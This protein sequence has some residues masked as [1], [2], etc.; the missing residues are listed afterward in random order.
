MPPSLRLVV[1][2][3]PAL[4]ARLQADTQPALL[5]R[6]AVLRLGGAGSGSE[7]VWGA[8]E[9]G[10]QHG[11]ANVRGAALA[12]LDTP[13][14]QSRPRSLLLSYLSRGEVEGG[15][16]LR[17]ITVTAATAVWARCCGQGKVKNKNK[18]KVETQ[19]ISES[20]RQSGSQSESQLEN[21]V[22]LEKCLAALL[23]QLLP[24]GNYHRR[25]LALDLL[26]ALLEQFPAC[27]S[28]GCKLAA[29]LVTDRHMQL[30][31][32]LLD[33]HM[34]DVKEK[35]AG[36]LKQFRPCQARLEQLQARLASLLCSPREGDS[37]TAA[38]LA[39]LLARWTSHSKEADQNQET[40]TE[41]YIIQNHKKN[42]DQ[43]PGSCQDKGRSADVNAEQVEYGVTYKDQD[44]EVD[45]KPI[46]GQGELVP[47][48]MMQARAS[49]A[50]WRGDPLSGAATS[51]LYPV[52]LTIRRLLLDRD[53]PQFGCLDQA[54]LD[55]LLSMLEQ[56]A[57]LMLTLLG[58]AEA[59]AGG[60]PDFQQ[61]AMAVRRA[62][63]AGEEG[64][65]VRLVVTAAW[66]SLK[67]VC[68]LA[69]GLGAG[70]DLL[71]HPQP[72]S[73]AL[74]L[75]G[76]ERCSLLL[77]NLLSCRHKGVVEAVAVGAGQ[78][79]VALLATPYTALA[80]LP[81]TML[82]TVLAGLA[83]A[84]ANT[85]YARRAAGLPGLVTALLTGEPPCLPR[86]LL[87]R[88]LASLVNTASGDDTPD[89]RAAGDAE[90]CPASHALHILRCM[91]AEACLARD[92]AAYLPSLA[93]ICLTAFSSHS[94]SV[95]NAGLQL[96]GALTPRLVG[97]QK[98]RGE[99]SGLN[100]VS[101]LDLE[102]RYPAL[103]DLLLPALLPRPDCLVPPGAVPVLTLLARL[104]SGQG[105]RTDFL[106]AGITPLAASPVH[107]V[108]V[109]AARVVA[110]F[111]PGT[112][113]EL[114]AGLLH[115]WPDLSSNLQH[116]NIAVVSHLVTRGQTGSPASLA[117]ALASCDAT[118]HCFTV[119]A[120][121]AEMLRGLAI[122]HGTPNTT[123]PLSGYSWEPGLAT[124]RDLWPGTSAGQDSREA[125][126]VA[127]TVRGVMEGG[128]VQEILAL[129]QQL[130]VSPH[131]Q[132]HAD[133]VYKLVSCLLSR[134]ALPSVLRPDPAQLIRPQ[135]VNSEEALDLLDCLDEAGAARVTG[136][137]QLRAA[138]LNTLLCQ[139]DW[140]WFFGDSSEYCGRLVVNTEEIQRLARPGSLE[141]ERLDAANALLQYSPALQTRQLRDKAV[142]VLQFGF[143]NLLNAALTLLE[144]EEEEVRQ[145]AAE[146]ACS[147]PKPAWA[148]PGGCVG[149]WAAVRLVVWYGLDQLHQVVEQFSPVQHTLLLP[150]QFSAECLPAVREPGR[151]CELFRRGDGVNVYREGSYAVLEY[152]GAIQEYLQR[153]EDCLGMVVSPSTALAA[154]EAAV[155]VMRT[156][157][158][159]ETGEGDVWSPGRTGEGYGQLCGVNASL[160]LL[161][162]QPVTKTPLSREVQAQ[163]AAMAG[164]LT[165]GLFWW[166][167]PP[168]LTSSVA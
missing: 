124:C 160:H 11:E 151:E 127:A 16:R 111:H 12:L 33:D 43:N 60:T 41:Q 93:S 80:A 83:G 110:Q 21:H 31:I 68:L 62:V 82:D 45:Q 4:L 142:L 23:S 50:C 35:A 102:C 49:L 109:L 78:L 140:E 165:A 10:L 30:L 162:T 27:G 34:T 138:A 104:E 141:T 42:I 70:L 18:K 54:G 91:V 158:G 14:D 73:H 164:E 126:D 99:G 107:Q 55:E 24:G 29:Y 163:L 5:A 22:W 67:Q 125:E 48:L 161:S 58:G 135:L 26:Q 133:L 132:A 76:A 145:V 106:L 79:A 32:L 28:P 61:M 100:C 51:P 105:P 115:T 157:S 144:D 139:D 87:P 77:L 168:T 92:L 1:E 159:R 40:G 155:A 46:P 129:L 9:R 101:L 89:L 134:S 103:L 25:V 156:E 116:F 6:L 7:E 57:E 137:P 56:T 147:L 65:E 128:T 154:G 39:S 69:G 166:P 3:R 119:K 95:R 38:L 36:V 84:W 148:P 66:H 167:Q 81:A 88:A 122:Q 98:V 130:V 59:Q 121:L 71:P 53:C 85:S 74:S 19:K 114:A 150:T 152:F 37:E 94:W 52:L 113:A 96:W 44:D 123:A 75:A 64:D 86:S 72:D 17:Q 90:D 108:R 118:T 2:A 149:R 63:G 97:Q 15:A 112:A 13:G 8:V 131:C 120:G 143:I 117:A 47:E 20:K 136:V 153:G 146:F